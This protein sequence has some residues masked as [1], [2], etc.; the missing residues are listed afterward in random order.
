VQ[1]RVD[2]PVTT[3]GEVPPGAS[4]ADPQGDH[5]YWGEAMRELRRDRTAMF[6]AALVA[7]L[8]VIAAAAPLIAPYEPEFQHRLGLSET[9]QP[10]SP[11]EEFRLGTDALGRDEL[12]RLVHGARISLVIGIGANV[13]AAVIGVALGGV[14]GMAGRVLQ[15]LIMRI[16]D[17]VLS[18]PVLLL[19]IAL[20]AVAQ[21]SVT[22]IVLII[23]I[24][25]GAYL[26]RI[27]YTQVVSLREREFVLAARTAGVSSGWILVR[28][29]VPH[30]VPSVIVFSTL[31]VATAIQ[32]EAALSYVGI[33]IRPPD[34]SWGNMISEGQT[35]LV[36]APWLVALPGAAIVLAMV[37]F[38]LLGDGLRDALDPRFRK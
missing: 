13:L 33:G 10:R 22:T 16:V 24:S 37:G 27:V 29:I 30:I 4:P 21:P 2:E 14:A 5:G 31:G 11:G 20:L 32:L 38:S 6:G 34:P 23:G 12:S 7:V 17:V 26:A 35:Y 9:G 19:A 25:F 18:F 15:T 3:I 1:G 8:V 28:H 36:T